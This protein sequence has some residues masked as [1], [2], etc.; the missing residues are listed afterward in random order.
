MRAQDF[1]EANPSWK[2]RHG[3]GSCWYFGRLSVG[4]RGITQPAV[5]T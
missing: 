5:W 4:V 2:G 3:G 1:R